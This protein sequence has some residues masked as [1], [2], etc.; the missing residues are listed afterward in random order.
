MP[1]KKKKLTKKTHGEKYKSSKI[2][3]KRNNSG[4][5]SKRKRKLTLSY[6]DL[7]KGSDDS[8]SIIA[9]LQ[10][11]ANVGKQEYPK[12]PSLRAVKDEEIDI[13]EGLSPINP[14]IMTPPMQSS[15][16]SNNQTSNFKKRL[17]FEDKDDDDDDDDVNMISN[18]S[19]SPLFNVVDESWTRV[20]GGKR[21]KKRKRTR[22]RKI[23]KRKIRKRKIRKRKRKT[24]RKKNN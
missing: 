4:N 17:S 11:Y 18:D 16:N 21:K 14:D 24:K 1:P 12:N 13:F 7:S 19:S 20:F 22:K 15:I 10:Q 5:K 6:I 3:Q 23:R 2:K 9:E 8:P